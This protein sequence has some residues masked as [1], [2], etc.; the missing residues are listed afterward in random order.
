MENYSFFLFSHL[1]V[2]IIGHNDD[3]YDIVFDRIRADYARFLKSRYNVDT[4][5]EHDCMVGWLNQCKSLGVSGVISH[6]KY[7]TFRYNALLELLGTTSMLGQVERWIDAK[8]ID[9]LIQHIED[10]LH[11]GG[12]GVPY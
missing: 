3:P 2:S 8:Q 12:V 5:S 4:K 6:D 1:F 11:E 10:Y 9:S 7:D